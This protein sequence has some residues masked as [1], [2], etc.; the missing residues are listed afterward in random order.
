M[1]TDILYHHNPLLY[2]AHYLLQE[3]STENISNAA[4]EY[5]AIQIYRKNARI[6]NKARKNKFSF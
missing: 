1:K 2:Q 6:I 5:I 4:A 3:A